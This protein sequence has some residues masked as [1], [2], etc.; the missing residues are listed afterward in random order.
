MVTDG[1]GLG[2]KKFVGNDSVVA[3]VAVE[4]VAWNNFTSG[5]SD[6]SLPPVSLQSKVE[7]GL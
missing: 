1:F 3:I 7:G 5:T 4:N 2:Q 6:G